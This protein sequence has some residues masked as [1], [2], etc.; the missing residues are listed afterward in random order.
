MGAYLEDAWY[1]A[2]WSHEVGGA[3]L[4]RRL[5]GEPILLYRLEDGSATALTDRCPHR[6]APL[7][8]GARQGDDV[9]CP[10]HGLTFDRTGACVR[11]PFGP[12][13]KG[14]SVRCWPVRE[15]DGILW[16]WPGDP[17]LAEGT[18]LPD[19]SR[20]HEGQPAA[21]ITGLMP[22][23]ANYEFGTDN[24]MDLSHIE[25]VHRGSFA[26]RGVIFAGEHQVQQE[27]D[28]LHS[29]WWMPDVAA[30]GHTYGIYPP[31]LRT[32]HWLD[33]RWQAP[34][35]ML[36]EIGATPAGQPRDQGVIVWQAHILTPETDGTAHYFWATTRSGG[37]VTEEGD[38]M[39]RALMGQAFVEEDKPIIEAAYA[40]LDGQDF[41]AAK[42]VFLGVDAGGTRARRLLQSLIS[43]KTH[44][45]SEA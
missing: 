11:N 24:L 45:G 2:A 39:L 30:P 40:N 13:P 7:S 36:L 28:F 8:M 27:G 21:P 42:P 26:G 35:T 29:N 3:L 44:E 43:R 10:Y 14:A 20:L 18:P 33:M 15:Q 17:A 38:G 41:W 12:P 23:N 22:M 9:T 19:F 16:F 5:L 6:F 25:F 37:P 31:D 4:R 32:D 34:A 1:M